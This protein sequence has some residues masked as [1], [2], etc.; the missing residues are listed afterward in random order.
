MR[1]SA[2]ITVALLVLVGCGTDDTTQGSSPTTE[3]RVP[4]D[5]PTIA[6]RTTAEIE[7]TGA[8][9]LVC[10]GGLAPCWDVIDGDGPDLAEGWATVE[11]DWA[12]GAIRVTALEGVEPGR[13]EFI[14]PCEDGDGALTDGDPVGEVTEELAAYLDSIPDELAAIWQSTDDGPLVVSVTDGV[15][16][17]RDALSDQGL[18]GICIADVGADVPLA[19]LEAAQEDMAEHFS[20]WGGS[21]WVVLSSS[22]EVMD[23]RVVI[24]FDEIDQRL[25]DEVEDEWGDLVH[26]DAIVEVLDGTVSDL[27][28]PTFPDDV[29]ISTQP[30]QRGGMAALGTFVLRYDAD[31]DCLYFE[32][33]DADR[34]KPIWPYGSRALRDPAV[35]V[36]GRGVALAAVDQEIEVGGG[37]GHL[38]PDADDPTDCGAESVWVIAP[39]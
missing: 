23:N 20:R 34:V 16:R 25:R 12:L 7:A 21:G 6:V 35:V 8:G 36:D 22:I 39:E 10:P 1:A 19:E 38:L 13:S 37:Y 17:H 32:G 18:G 31:G 24:S 3:V 5:A 33:G 15:D 4:D 2:C 28:P 27:A 9:W 30:R 29:P 11:G 26:I 14:D